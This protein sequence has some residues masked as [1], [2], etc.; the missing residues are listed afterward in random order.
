MSARLKK[1]YKRFTA[2]REVYN[3]GASRR[4]GGRE[5]QKRH[6]RQKNS[7]HPS[8]TSYLI[9]VFRRVELRRVFSIALGE[10]RKRERE[11]R[12]A[13]WERKQDR[14][15]EREQEH[16]HLAAFINASTFIKATPRTLDAP[17]YVFRN[18]CLV[19]WHRDAVV[20]ARERYE[21]WNIPLSYFHMRAHDKWAPC[22]WR[23]PASAKKR[24]YICK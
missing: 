23:S 9:D 5:R 13:G 2:T 7:F 6:T 11:E 12:E 19:T 1:I 24:T 21:K 10:R 14:K 20:G 8:R 18:E 4:G 16:S 3:G 22:V 17:V 15:G